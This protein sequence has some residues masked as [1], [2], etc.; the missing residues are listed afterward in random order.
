MSDNSRARPIPATLADTASL[1]TADL[2]DDKLAT[3]VQRLVE[4]AYAEGYADG[5]HRGRQ[6]QTDRAFA[7]ERRSKQA[8]S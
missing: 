5:H 6:E 3:T 7:Y 8:P 1:V 4:S 2:P